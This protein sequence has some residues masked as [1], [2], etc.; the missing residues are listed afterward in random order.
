MYVKHLTKKL[1]LYACDQCGKEFK[2]YEKDALD[3]QLC[4]RECVSDATKIGGVI[5]RKT[6][7]TCMD[8]FGV[9]TPFASSDIRLKLKQTIFEKYGVQNVSQN[10]N[11]RKK[12][13]HTCME[14]YG[15]ENVLASKEIREKARTTL[16]N[17]YNV[18]APQQ[19]NEIQERTKQTNI[20]RYG[21]LNTLQLSYARERCNSKE[22]HRKRHET[23]KRKGTYRKSK[24]EDK[25]Y[26]LLCEWF[27]CDDVERQVSVH[28]WPIDFYV[29]SID[30]YFQLD[31]VYWHGLNRPIEV[32]A[33]LK[34]KRDVSIMNKW[35]TDRE[36]DQWFKI[37]GLNLVRVTDLQLRNLG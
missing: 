25:L 21:V 13:M 10:M 7:K 33:E 35:K 16:Q 26:A 28:K 11:V 36:Q 18:D 17:N 32:I 9:E 2:R 23:M 20:E 37:H 8:K 31:G 4:S 27:S 14:K 24:P 34:S 15:V 29:K 22:S 6:S 19:S 5:W 12:I 3:L 1:A 30:T